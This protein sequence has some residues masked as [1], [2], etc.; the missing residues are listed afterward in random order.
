MELVSAVIL[1]ALINGTRLSS[2]EWLG[3]ALVVMAA[4]VEAR[5]PA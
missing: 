2:L 5:R 3:G 4:L 1:A